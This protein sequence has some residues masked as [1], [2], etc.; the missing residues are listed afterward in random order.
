VYRCLLQLHQ[1]S[2]GI[3]LR[4]GHKG[5]LPNP[6]QFMTHLSSGAYIFSILEALLRSPRRHALRN[7]VTWRN[8]SVVQSSAFKYMSSQWDTFRWWRQMALAIIEY[9]VIPRDYESFIS[10]IN[11]L[12]SKWQ[13]RALIMNM[14][15]DLSFFVFP[16]ANTTAE[17][18]QRMELRQ[19][20]T[21]R[22][23]VFL[24]ETNVQVKLLR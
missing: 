22:L 11:A 21:Y 3:I 4:L 9:S 8:V 13:Q 18:F 7:R 23:L 16:V 2:A 24:K 1:A 5:F 14:T 12:V 20:L 17:C 6:F 15:Y 19:V 10:I